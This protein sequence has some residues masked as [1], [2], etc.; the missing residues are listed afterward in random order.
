MCKKYVSAV[1]NVPYLDMGADC[2]SSRQISTFRLSSAEGFCKRKVKR[3]IRHWLQ[4]KM[5]KKVDM[6]ELRK[7]LARGHY[8][9]A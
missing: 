7:V 4:W 8:A 2:N 6:Q 5:D 9:T 1:V 3:Y